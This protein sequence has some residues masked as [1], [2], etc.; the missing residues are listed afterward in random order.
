MPVV[1]SRSTPTMARMANRYAA[2]SDPLFSFNVMQ[3]LARKEQVKQAFFEFMALQQQKREERKAEEKGGRG[4]GAG[5]GA[6]IGTLVAPG[7]GT[8]IGAKLG[9]DIGGI[10][11]PAGSPEAGAQGQAIQ[12]LAPFMGGMT[13]GFR[14]MAG[15]GKGA[16]PFQ[17]FGGGFQSTMMSP[18]MLQWAEMMGWG[19]YENMMVA[20]SARFGGG[21][22]PSPSAPPQRNLVASYDPMSPRFY[23]GGQWQ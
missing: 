17:T 4:T 3:P 19:G 14:G 16:N 10:V 7:V 5:I 6:A 8:A 15:A 2:R 21:G 22:L 20:P 12:D 11:D 18:E 23:Y 13:G 1:P 9:G